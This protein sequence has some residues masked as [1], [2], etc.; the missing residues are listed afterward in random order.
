MRSWLAVIFWFALG[1]IVAGAIRPAYEWAVF[2]P[3][4]TSYAQAHGVEHADALAFSDLTSPRGTG[5][6]FCNMTDLAT[7]FPVKI[8]LQLSA[9]QSA[10]F[11]ALRLLEI[12]C[13]AVPVV[14][15]I[16]RAA[17]AMPAT[18]GA[19]R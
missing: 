16:I 18:S 5:K 2:R 7:G 17:R 3:L 14:Y 8:E 15:G 9:L 13:M 4:C 19:S 12:G 6:R 11:E 1:F 10:G